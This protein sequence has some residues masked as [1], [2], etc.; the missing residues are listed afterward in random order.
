MRSSLRFVSG[1]MLLFCLIVISVIGA[2]AGFKIH[3]ENRDKRVY[4]PP[5]GFVNAPFAS[6]TGQAF[7]ISP[8]RKPVKAATPPVAQVQVVSQQSSTGSQT[9]SQKVTFSAPSVAPLSQSRTASKAASKAALKQKMQSA[10]IAQQVIFVVDKL[11]NNSNYREPTDANILVNTVSNETTIVDPVSNE[12]T[13]KTETQANILN[14]SGCYQDLET[15]QRNF[16]KNVKITSMTVQ[17]VS[18]DKEHL[19]CKPLREGLTIPD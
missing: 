11:N 12:T 5:H 1:F 17:P 6:I 19:I 15:A 4:Q 16:G 9:A 7:D 2:V 13:T 3:N 8:P 10:P 14:S 18:Q